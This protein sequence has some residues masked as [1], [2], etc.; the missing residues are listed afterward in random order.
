VLVFV[1]LSPAFMGHDGC[2]AGRPNHL[3]TILSTKK[4][5]PPRVLCVLCFVRE[6]IMEEL[7]L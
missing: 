2:G 3:I 4:S 5:N 1:V 6:S 7:D